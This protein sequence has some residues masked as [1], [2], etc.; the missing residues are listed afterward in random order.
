[1]KLGT[2][3][4]GRFSVSDLI[5]PQ[6]PLGVPWRLGEGAVI[7]L[8][9]V[10]AVSRIQVINIILS[11]SSVFAVERACFYRCSN[12]KTSTCCS[13]FCLQQMRREIP[14]GKKKKSRKLHCKRGPFSE[15][16]SWDVV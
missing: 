1:M 3:T 4:H 11:V 13:T 2:S 10:F 9:V 8:D 14:I 15:S 7:H 16:L 5:Y 12:V 6:V